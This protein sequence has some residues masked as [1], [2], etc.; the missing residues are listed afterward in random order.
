MEAQPVQVPVGALG[1][2]LDTN[3]DWLSQTWTDSF[4]FFLIKV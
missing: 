4:S 1:V 3:L 2:L